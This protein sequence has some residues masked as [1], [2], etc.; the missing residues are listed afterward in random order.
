MVLAI[1]SCWD[2][3]VQ[4]GLFKL[5]MKSNDAQAMVDMVVIASNK[6]NPIIVNPFTRF[7][8]SDPCITTFVSFF[9]RIPIVG[10]EIAMV[11]VLG[12]MEDECYFSSI[13]FL[14]KKCTIN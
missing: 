8:V 9:S 4:Q 10:R 11:H 5:I 14:K 1:L 12:F 6:A 13:S 7:V 3:D 2:L